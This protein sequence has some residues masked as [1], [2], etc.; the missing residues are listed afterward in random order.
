MINSELE[1][2]KIVSFARELYDKW[3]LTSKQVYNT[4]N[5]Q[6]QLNLPY[7]ENLLPNKLING[8]YKTITVKYKD[9]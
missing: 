6:Y 7:S 1:K 8:K 4:Y 3:E 5:E 9:L 2:V